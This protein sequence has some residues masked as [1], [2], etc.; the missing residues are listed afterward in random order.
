MNRDEKGPPMERQETVRLEIVSVL[1]A[2][3]PMT[4]RE[5][6]TEVRVRERE[7]IEHLEHIRKSLAKS[8]SELVVTPSACRKCDFV[9]TERKRL[10]KPGKCPLCRSTSVEGPSFNVR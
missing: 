8:D 9:F 5:L 10:T 4:A 2:F 1:K 6:S 3:G 7:V